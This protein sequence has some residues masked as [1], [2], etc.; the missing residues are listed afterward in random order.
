M[1]KRNQYI[2]RLKRFSNKKLIAIAQKLGLEDMSPLAKTFIDK[3]GAKIV[4]YKE[5]NN[6]SYRKDEVNFSA[7]F[8]K[9]FSA[10]NDAGKD[11]SRKYRRIMSSLFPKYEQ[12]YNNYLV[13]KITKNKK[14]NSNFEEKSL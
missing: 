7:I 11:L 3:K 5:D 14:N 10:T 12:D 9:E 2:N 6:Y 1:Y 8:L 4:I 13:N